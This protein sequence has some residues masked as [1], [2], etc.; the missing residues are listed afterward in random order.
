M[1]SS[2]R[3]KINAQVV[4]VKTGIRQIPRLPRWW[5]VQQ[6]YDKYPRY[7]GGGRYNRYT[8]NTHVTYVVIGKTGIRQFTW[9]TRWWQVNEVGS[10]LSFLRRSYF[11]DSGHG[12]FIDICHA[13]DNNKIV[14]AFTRLTDQVV[15]CLKVYN[16]FCFETIITL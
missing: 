5:Q 3:Y 8:T 11:S 7:L 4:T 16:V 6:V 10:S 14:T 1:V 2:N 13:C 9:L 15:Y 12:Q